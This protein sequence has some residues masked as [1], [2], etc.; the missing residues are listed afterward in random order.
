MFRP[1]KK[2]INVD[3]QLDKSEEIDR[4]IENDGLEPSYDQTWQRYG[5]ILNKDQ[6]DKHRD[7]LRDLLKL[8]YDFRNG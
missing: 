2:T 7:L 5:L 8:S 1:R 6:F 4:K 3:A